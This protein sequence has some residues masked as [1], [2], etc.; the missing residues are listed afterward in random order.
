MGFVAL[1]VFGHFLVI[2]DVFKNLWEVLA[3][4]LCILG[5]VLVIIGG[6]IAHGEWEE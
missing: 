3:F 2:E 6:F 4:L 5:G 1:D